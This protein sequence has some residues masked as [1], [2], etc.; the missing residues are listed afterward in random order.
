M[1]PTQLPDQSRLAREAQRQG[2]G[3]NSHN[4]L[5]VGPSGAGDRSRG[6]TLED[7][8]PPA[9]QEAIGGG[10]FSRGDKEPSFPTQL[11][12]Q[13]R[14]NVQHGKTEATGWP[15]SNA[16]IQ[17]DEQPRHV[18]HSAYQQQARES[19]EQF[20]EI[21]QAR[22]VQGRPQEAGS[23]GDDSHQQKQQGAD[24]LSHDHKSS[25]LPLAYQQQAR[26][27]PQQ[28]HGLRH[29][30]RELSQQPLGTEQPPVVA[31]QQSTQASESRVGLEGQSGTPPYWGSL[32]TA[33]TGGIYNTVTGHGSARDDHDQHHTALNKDRNT[34]Q[35]AADAT[36]PGAATSF[37]TGGIY[38]SVTG[39]GSNDES[40]KHHQAAG[41]DDHSTASSRVP[42]LGA[43]QSRHT[44]HPDGSN[45]SFGGVEPAV[46]ENRTTDRSSDIKPSHTHG[47]EAR[48][49][50][51]SNFGE[52]GTAGTQRAFPLATSDRD[53]HH[54]DKSHSRTEQGLA[55]GALAGTGIAAY[56]FS[57]KHANQD[58][59]GA[60]DVAAS[61]RHAPTNTEHR[62]TQ[63]QH[64]SHHTHTVEDTTSSGKKDKSKEHHG[65]FGHSGKHAAQEKRDS[66]DI[67]PIPGT[68]P[69]RVEHRT[70]QPEAISPPNAEAKRSSVD[71]K[72]S[73]KEDSPKRK[74]SVLGGIFHR[75]RGDNNEEEPKHQGRRSGSSERRK[76]HKEPPQAVVA[77]AMREST[78][79]K[80]TSD[81]GDRYRQTGAA[82]G[83]ALP[84]TH[85]TEKYAETSEH[86]HDSRWAQGAGVA[87]GGLAVSEV[88]HRQRDSHDARNQQVE[89]NPHTAGTSSSGAYNALPSG[90]PSGVDTGVADT[91][92][93]S[94]QPQNAS[95]IAQGG[96][97]REDYT[98][99]GVAAGA[100]AAAPLI[101]SRE[102]K[103]KESYGNTHGATTTQSGSAASG[104]DWRSSLPPTVATS[105]EADNSAYRSTPDTHSTDYSAGNYN[106]A[107]SRPSEITMPV[108]RSHDKQSAAHTAGTPAH[109]DTLGSSAASGVAAAAVSHSATHGASPGVK[110]N[111]IPLTHRNQDEAG[112]S[113]DLPNPYNV[114]PSGTPSG[115]NIDYK[116][117]SKEIERQH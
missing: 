68:H 93:Q 111:S 8:R 96:Y 26:E 88:V 21:P 80:T 63:A 77:Q 107:A 75:H 74:G 28:H 17:H 106:N 9:V 34:A 89:T 35:P 73:H 5:G 14:N 117:G 11:E 78:P 61:H 19:P 57:S 41:S 86:D 67:S 43:G 101:A 85:A 100:V 69:S 3:D 24:S 87:A 64:T 15:L 30:S 33:P 99:S 6:T 112:H 25:D 13:P 98:T 36:I 82:D 60:Q 79:P 91:S 40:T 50:D 104:N 51:S 65:L 72:D 109:H 113:S 95:H 108:G 81:E 27:A 103:N 54:D 59:R 2:S 110:D 44:Q 46:R 58:G 66:K 92:Y 55:A 29:E 1:Q 22:A 31:D 94:S 116:R 37:P 114:L 97:G 71:G 90:T 62:A 12:E 16:N 52:S 47:S 7:D 42:L 10:T 18:H 76:L 105:R 83:A 53:R 4:D 23:R 84:T 39:H 32:A 70:V 38:N 45:N 48:V 115:V 102:A 56:E 20:H 49:T